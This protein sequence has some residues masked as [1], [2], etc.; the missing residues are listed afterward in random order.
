MT[1]FHKC[2]E[3]YWYSD[4]PVKTCEHEHEPANPNDEAC[5]YFDYYEP[6]KVL[7]AGENEE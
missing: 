4:S 1:E 6:N 7:F 5:M 2:K 3:C